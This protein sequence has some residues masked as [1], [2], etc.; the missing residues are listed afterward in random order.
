MKL[1][2]TLRL[3]MNKYAYIYPRQ[4]GKT[5]FAIHEF[6][7]LPRDTLFICCD[8]KMISYL[9]RNYNLSN[10]E[11]N[12][13]HS[14]SSSMI[15]RPHPPRVYRKIILDEYLFFS[16]LKKIREF[17]D[18]I[19]PEDLYIFSTADYEYNGLL[20]DFVRKFKNHMHPSGVSPMLESAHFMAE[21][22]KI[23]KQHFVDH[24]LNNFL[25][26][27][28]TK[29]FTIG[30]DGIPKHLQEHSEHFSPTEIRTRIIGKYKYDFDF[31]TFD[32][33]N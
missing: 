20:F 3:I 27:N 31:K 22:L 18:Y 2:P 14:Q 19:R 7:K 12:N 25:T 17:V 21:Y 24:Y 29:I 28:D 6:K 33:I 13:F 16:N 4:T 9:K 10:K 11:L 5:T 8:N 1:K 26:D 32:R 23:N 15:D 30:R